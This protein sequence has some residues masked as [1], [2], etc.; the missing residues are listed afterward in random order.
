MYKEK[1]YSTS[2]TKSFLTTFLYVC[3]F[4]VKYLP[5][6]LTMQLILNKILSYFYRSPKN[7]ACFFLRAN[8][9]WRFLVVSNRGWQGSSPYPGSSN[10]DSRVW[11]S[12]TRSSSSRAGRY[13]RD[14]SWRGRGRGGRRLATPT[15]W[16]RSAPSALQG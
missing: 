13:S 10:T 6:F 15:S 2:Y 9:S 4:K 12:S 11:M 5:R 16:T 7:F 8:F 14:S 1:L 3:N